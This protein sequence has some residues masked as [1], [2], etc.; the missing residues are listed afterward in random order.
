MFPWYHGS[1]KFKELPED[2]RLAIQQIYGPRVKEWGR[3]EL[4]RNPATRPTTTTTTTAPRSYY[5]DRTPTD[6]EIEREL[7][8]RI[9]DR[10]ERDRV[11]RERKERERERQREQ[12]EREERERNRIEKEKERE[13]MKEEQKRK[14]E[15]RER[16]RERER[17]S[18]KPETCDTSYDAVTIIRGELFIFKDRVSIHSKNHYHSDQLTFQHT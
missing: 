11:E 9:R 2:D 17:N 4:P 10:D 15:K 16:D 7:E 5:P 8:K 3:N 13:R 12:H 1:T 14:W 18:K 6:R